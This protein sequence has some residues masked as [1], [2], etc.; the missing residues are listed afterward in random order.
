MSGQ[1]TRTLTRRGIEKALVEKGF[2][3]RESKRL[4]S[5][6]INAMVSS[7]KTNKS[8]VVP[9]GTLEVRRTK[10][11]RIMTFGTFVERFR[12]GYRVIFVPDKA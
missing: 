4:T 11:H 8:L 3:I 2:T 10:A 7:L 9:F 12:G 5:A 6:I 1:K